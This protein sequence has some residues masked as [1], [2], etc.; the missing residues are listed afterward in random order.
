MYDDW[1][2]YQPWHGSIFT[3]TSWYV[4]PR[5]L[6]RA[7]YIETGGL[8]KSNTVICGLKIALA[9]FYNCCVVFRLWA[10]W[11]STKLSVGLDNSNARVRVSSIDINGEFTTQTMYKLSIRL[12]KVKPLSATKKAGNGSKENCLAKMNTCSCFATT[13]KSHYSAVSIAVCV[14]EPVSRD[15]RTILLSQL[16][17]VCQSQSAVIGTSEHTLTFTS[18]SYVTLCC[19]FL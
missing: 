5:N 13:S 4:W 7:D 6:A 10:V 16:L 1:L 3:V 12:V 2:Y 19:C 14:P 9:Y 15:C 11:C 17:C 8:C 18:L